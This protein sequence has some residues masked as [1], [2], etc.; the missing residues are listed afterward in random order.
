[1]LNFA[2]ATASAAHPFVGLRPFT[3]DDAAYF[4]GREQQV[5]ALERLVSLGRMVSVVGNSGSGKSSLIRAG[6]LPRLSGRDGDAGWD[7]VE[8]RP[9]EAPMRNLA[10][11][12]ARLN[13][14][15]DTDM[16]DPLAE[17]RA[18]RFEMVLQQSSFGIGEA[19]AQR[20]NPQ[21][22]RMLILVD[23]FE[24]IFRFAD[25][26]TRRNR[27][28]RRA[29][30]QRDEAT[31]FVQSLL[32]AVAN[33]A[34]PA[35]I[36]LTMRSDFIGECARF[37]GL[38]ETVTQ[39]QYLVPA[40][41]RDQRATAIRGPI[42]RAGGDCDPAVVQRLLNDSNE[43]PD[44]LPVMQ[45]A[46]MRCWQRASL[47]SGKDGP[48]ITLDTYQSIHGFE[49]ALTQHGDEVLDSLVSN[50]TVDIGRELGEVAQRVFQSLTEVDS[51][52]RVIRRPQTLADLVAVVAPK[53]NAARQSATEAAVRQVVLHFADPACSFLRAPRDS[54]LLPSSIIDIGHEALI[55]RWERLGGQDT[56]SWVREEQADADEYR[57]LLFYSGDGELIPRGQLRNFEAWWA[58]R[59]PTNFWAK[60]YTRG[61][62]DR[63]DGAAALLQNS[64]RKVVRDKQQRWTGI[65]ALVILVAG[66]ASLFLYTQRSERLAAIERADNSARERAR[67]VAVEGVD[68]LRHRSPSEALLLAIYGLQPE[69]HLP[70]VQ[71][72]E[73]LAYEALEQ[74]RERNI[75]LAAGCSNAPGVGFMP[76][77]TLLTFNAMSGVLQF[78]NVETGAIDPAREVAGIR[79]PYAWNLQSSPSGNFILISS[80]DQALLIDPATHKVRNLDE[81]R[82]RPGYGVLS[83]DGTMIVTAG[84]NA[85]VRLWRVAPGEGDDPFPTI[86]LAMDF[87]N[88][89]IPIKTAQSADLSA[90][91][92]L[93]AVGGVTSGNEA[94]HPDLG[95]IQ[96]FDTADVAW[97]FDLPSP[98]AR[99]MAGQDPVPVTGVFSVVFD[100]AGKRLLAGYM[101]APAQLWD[102]AT[103]KSVRLADSPTGFSRAV[104][105][106]DG[107]YLIMTSGDER[108]RVWDTYATPL[109]GALPVLITQRGSDGPFFSV[110]TDG[111]GRVVTGS[112]A[113][114][115]WV[116]DKD[117]ALSRGLPI[118]PLDAGPHEAGGTA[119]QAGKDSVAVQSSVPGI[120]SGPLTIPADTVRFPV[121]AS[122][123]AD[124]MW[125]LVAPSTGPV[126]VYDLRRPDSPIASLG[127]IAAHWK[128]AA[129]AGDPDHI[130]GLRDEGGAQAWRFFRKRADLLTFAQAALP[131]RGGTPAALSADIRDKLDGRFWT[132][133]ATEKNESDSAACGGAAGRARARPP[134]VSQ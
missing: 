81:Q 53:D 60:R 27:D 97:K 79:L 38:S 6:L 126:L 87:E 105:S 98:P 133:L 8:M 9:G 24:E 72:N 68:V 120:P 89:V 118:D 42:N 58:R 4:F 75:I 134:T 33:E 125:A 128:G 5:A 96:V 31:F 19:L 16:H 70:V 124:G 28:D 25:L 13:R 41:T 131:L 37:H 63:L 23:Q 106:T 45:H 52:G 111:R 11:A 56:D 49:G 103:R 88:A 40:L 121:S 29:A 1:M 3:F 108:V 93:L 99:V 46:I 86:S 100:P 61:G 76:D 132:A 62:E 17:A 39:T 71:E 36:M 90:R 119:I 115:V 7:W 104:F 65:A 73:A 2:D 74:M 117:A 101:G 82:P 122:V 94:V 77:G 14:S 44:Q 92:R 57:R 66:T 18:D 15:A 85:P 12:L 114:T 130:V 32:S 64:R 129:F 20:P 78:W 95:L 107:R 51:Q 43:D 109:D 127:A 30:E 116:W 84:R 113:G 47:A 123:S 91:S 110:A 34:L 54:E 67:S 102:L 112:L 35:C 10:E 48:R 22:R 55:R 59:Q 26:R 83:P 80:Q 21:G 69:S 50:G